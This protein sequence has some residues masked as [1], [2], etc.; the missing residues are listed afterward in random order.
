MHPRSKAC[1]QHQQASCSQCPACR[2]G[3]RQRLSP[4][5]AAAHA[6]ASSSV[7]RPASATVPRVMPGAGR[8]CEQHTRGVSADPSGLEGSPRDTAAARHSHPPVCQIERASWVAGAGLL[9]QQLGSAGSFTPGGALTGSERV[10]MTRSAKVF[11]RDG[12]WGVQPPPRRACCAPAKPPSCLS[13]L[14]RWPCPQRLGPVAPQLSGSN[15]TH[16]RLW[17]NAAHF[18]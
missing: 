4:A 7:S 2:C 14:S 5:A 18:A 12:G 13:A 8:A 11:N 6:P 1:E 15:C 10:Q 16:V 17:P 9:V 3:W